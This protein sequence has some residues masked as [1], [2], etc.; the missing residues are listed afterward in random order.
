MWSFS[1][2]FTHI[3]G[4]ESKPKL[5]KFEETFLRF[6]LYIYLVLS[7]MIDSLHSDHLNNFNL[8]VF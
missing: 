1:K 4:G 3:G 8:K 5:K 6:I 2:Y 7:V